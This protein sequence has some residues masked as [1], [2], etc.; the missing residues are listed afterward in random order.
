MQIKLEQRTLWEKL[1]LNLTGSKIGRFFIYFSLSIWSLTTIFPLLWIVN[2]SFKDSADVVNNSFA[3]AAD[4]T[5]QNY[6]NAFQSMNVGKSYLNSFIMSG[7]TVFFVL[8]FGGMA[9]FIL[10]RF[11]FR[12]RGFIQ[13][14]LVLSLLIPSFATVLPVFELLIK[15]NLLNTHWALILPHTAGYLPFA[16]LVL[17]GYMATIPK[18]LEEAAVM[19]GCSRLKMYTRIF[20]PIS[21]P[22]FATCSVFVFLWSYND[23]FSSLIFVGQEHIRPIVV[24]LS[25][26]SSQYG[27]DYGLMATAVTITVIPVLVIY[28]FVQ[29]FIEK[30]LTA[31]AVKG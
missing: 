24:L 15:M 22:S 7:G 31:G 29:R 1:Q 18:E 27:T 14:I 16:V 10:S 4:P 25:F 13:G 20:F 19:D 30:G 6:V 2:N 12:L 3:I 28:L 17:S 8:L 11:H 23:L 9:A 5:L 26:I 21:R